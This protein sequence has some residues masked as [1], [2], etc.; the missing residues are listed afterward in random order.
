MKMPYIGITG[1]VSLNDALNVLET[2]PADSNRLVMVGVL[3][4]LKTRQ[5][6]PNKYPNRYPAINKIAGI[7]PKHPLVLNLI[8]YNTGEKETLG[9]QLVDM[10]EF[11]G[12]NLHGFQLNIA[13]PSPEILAKYRK[14]FPSKKIVLQI[15]EHALTMVNHSPKRLAAKVTEY[16]GIIDYVLLDPSGGHGKPFEPERAQD[17]LL[18]LKTQN[19]ETG[20]GVAGGLSPR[21][22]NLVEPLAK[23]FPNLSIDAESRLRTQADHMDIVLANAYLQKALLLFT[24]A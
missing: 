6:I 22:L 15:G 12:A 7:F 20:L 5:G 23:E 18:A 11:G 13:W 2:V 10:M 14:S 1:F 21:T 19:P 4:S 3:A 9:D 17:Y 24:D 16:G 8:H